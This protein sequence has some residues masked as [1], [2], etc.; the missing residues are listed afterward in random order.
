MTDIKL[1]DKMNDT[2]KEMLQL[3]KDP[4]SLYALKR[5]EYLEDVVKSFSIHNVSHRR[6]LLIDFFRKL[7]KVSINDKGNMYT[8]TKAVED[9]LKDN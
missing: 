9:Y 3:R 8:V 6:E 2:V 5:I 1:N 7:S 4:M